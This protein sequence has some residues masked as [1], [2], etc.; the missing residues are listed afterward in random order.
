MKHISWGIIGCGDVTEL[1]SGPAFS[2]VKSSHLLAVMRRDGVKAKDYARRHNVPQW[3]DDPSFLLEN[4][5]INAIYIATPPVFHLEYAMKALANGKNVYV[6]KPMVLNA[7]EAVQLQTAVEQ[8]S[9]KLVVA[10]YRRF[11]P[12]FLKVKEIIAQDLGAISHIEL[13]FSR[14]ENTTLVTEENWRENPS[15]SGGGLFYDLAPHQIDLLYYF[16]GKPISYSGSADKDDTKG[17]PNK[18]IDGSIQF[19][20]NIQFKGR[21]NFKS[22][23]KQRVDICS[24]HGENGT[25]CFAVFG[26][27]LH[28]EIAG[29]TEV[30]SFEHPENIQFPMIQQTVN[31]F[32]GE[33]DNPCSVEDG[34]EVAKI[35]D[36]FSKK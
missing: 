5:D 34:L 11:L 7:S 33:V 12:M 18:Q 26:N 2:K 9:G 1:K 15:I 30:L 27:S 24:I 21:W 10:H 3:S 28:L 16:F 22:E 4:S 31:Y 36:S 20:N 6:E 19:E 17:F 29:K 32:L 13:D 25:L 14:P 35:M 8:S 23:K